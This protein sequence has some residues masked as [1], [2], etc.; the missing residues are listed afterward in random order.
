ML[1]T[2]EVARRAGWSVSFVPLEPD[3]LQARI[4]GTVIDAPPSDG[5]Q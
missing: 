3:G 1:I 5:A 2:R 4:E